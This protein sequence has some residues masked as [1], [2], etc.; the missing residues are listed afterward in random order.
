[1]GGLSFK[2]V[3][4]AFHTCGVTTANLVYCWG[5]NYFGQLGDGTTTS[6]S[7]PVPIAGGHLFRTVTVGFFHTC[8]VSYPDNR[9]YCWGNNAYGQLGDGTT[10]RRLIP[11]AV[12]GGRQFSSLDAGGEYS[13]GVTTDY[14]AFC[15]GRNERGQLGDSTAV[16][17]RLRPSRVAG[18]R[19][20][21]R[22]DAGDWHT[23]GVTSNDRAYCW[24]DGRHGEIGNGQTYLSYW[25]RAVAGGLLFRRVTAAEFHS[26]GETTTN[27]TYCW[28]W[29]RFGQI[30]DGTTYR[31]LKPVAVAGGLYFK[32]VS[33]GGEHTCGKTGDAVAY[34]WG[35]NG[36]GQ[37]GDGTLVNRLT[38]TKVAGAM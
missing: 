36:H 5:Y 20:W 8:A 17:Q 1:V 10:G 33:A 9:A 26:C 24:G 28:G 6:R 18:A 3:S 38:P 22:L 21:R 11:V 7:R 23:C 30:G 12:A 35:W 25:P 31:R 19:Q 15:W 2:Q 16:L 4:T 13:C 34:C 37:L 29:N 27:G 32:Q 14:R